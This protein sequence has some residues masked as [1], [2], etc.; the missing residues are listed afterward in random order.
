MI[1]F[2]ILRRY[3]TTPVPR[4]SALKGS[5]REM[6]YTQRKPTNIDEG[7]YAFLRGGRNPLNRSTTFQ[8]SNPDENQVRN[9]KNKCVLIFFNENFLAGT[10]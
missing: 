3:S 9:F 1:Y 8:E 7:D 10:Y 5:Y 4:T 2:R 6:S